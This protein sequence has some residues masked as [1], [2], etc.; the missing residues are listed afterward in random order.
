MNRLRR[1]LGDDL[2]A[3][4]RNGRIRLRD[5][6]VGFPLRIGDMV[7]HLPPDF[8]VTGRRETVT[9]P[10]RP[11]GGDGFVEVVSRRLGPTV[12]AEFYE[13][14]ARKLYGDRARRPRW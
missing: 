2:Q 6:W 8:A 11:R 5:R 13:P 14:Y 1:L 12:P 7:R 3:R 9:G 4:D 10:R